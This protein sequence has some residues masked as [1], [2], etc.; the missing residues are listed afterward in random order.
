MDQG[1]VEGGVLQPISLTLRVGGN[2]P[3]WARSLVH[4]CPL[5][6]SRGQLVVLAKTMPR[7]H[8]YELSH[9]IAKALAQQLGHHLGPGRHKIK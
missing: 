2:N 9:I 5:I 3:S 1:T 6:L 7:S 4:A 8:Q